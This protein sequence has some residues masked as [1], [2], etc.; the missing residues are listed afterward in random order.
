MASSRPR[1]PT[2][3]REESLSIAR[4]VARQSPL[5]VRATT[6]TLRAA[7]GSGLDAA[8]Q[9]EADAQ[10]QSYGSEDYAEGLAALREKRAPAFPGTL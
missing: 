9:R 2:L 10:A 5:A 8:L 1:C 3:A 7:S 6:A 4:R